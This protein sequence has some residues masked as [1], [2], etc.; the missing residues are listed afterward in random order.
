MDVDADDNWYSI[1]VIL[2]SADQIDHYT[3]AIHQEALGSW[4]A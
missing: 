3:R 2:L 4:P 1:A